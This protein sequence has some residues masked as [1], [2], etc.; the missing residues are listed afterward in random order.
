MTSIMF[1]NVQRLGARTDVEIRR[2]IDRVSDAQGADY[3]IYC[4]LTQAC[5]V[6]TPVNL[7]YRKKNAHQL[8]YGARDRAGN[9]LPMQRLTPRS[10]P[11][12]ATAAALQRYGGDRLFSNWTD[13]A[14]A[15]FGVLDGVHVYGFH[16]PAYALGGERSVSFLACYLNQLHGANPWLLIGDMNVSPQQLAASPVALNLGNFII[17]TGIRTHQHYGELDYALT[18]VPNRMR[19]GRVRANHGFVWSDHYA[20]YVRW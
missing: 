3:Q 12:Y 13:R 7:T 18:N 6:M 8:A 10:T 4:E 19:I 9:D 17:R 5:T 14:P 15:D 16:A 2:G 11:T 1:W 20:I